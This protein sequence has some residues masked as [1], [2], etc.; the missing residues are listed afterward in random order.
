MN[1]A[2]DNQGRSAAMTALRAMAITAA[3]TGEIEDA[4]AHPDAELLRLCADVLDRHAE[5][6][7]TWRDW[8]ALVEAE[9]S[10][11]GEPQ[12]ALTE[13]VRRLTSANRLP[14]ARVGRLAA[15]TGAGVHA[16]ALVL[17]RSRGLA[18]KLALSLA[19]DVLALR[20][21]RAGDLA[22]TPPA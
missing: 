3:Q 6:D 8:R 11:F 7:A 14:I 20:G 10:G 5:I 17:R 2:N 9:R 1:E 4:P 13:K 12:R 21:L 16:K 18:P 19:N 15:A 22:E